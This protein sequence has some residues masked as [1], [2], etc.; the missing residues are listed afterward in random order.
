MDGRIFADS[1]EIKKSLL[2]CIITADA[3]SLGAPLWFETPGRLPISV[4]RAFKWDVDS[5]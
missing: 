4:K 5:R 3:V 1:L 2:G